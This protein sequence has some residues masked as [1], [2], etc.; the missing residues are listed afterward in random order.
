MAIRSLYIYKPMVHVKNIGCNYDYIKL[1]VLNSKIPKIEPLMGV[2]AS[3]QDI[4]MSNQRSKIV[5]NERELV[6]RSINFFPIA[7]ISLN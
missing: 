7:Q 6:S 2:R 4:Q 1:S 3:F 5:G